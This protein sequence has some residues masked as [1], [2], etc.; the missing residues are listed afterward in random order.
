MKKNKQNK[1][2]KSRKKENTN[3]LGSIHSY[4]QNNKFISFIK[5]KKKKII[6]ISLIFII[7]FLLM[8]YVFSIKIRF[9]LKEQM[10]LE[11]IPLEKSFTIPRDENISINFSIKLNTPR[12]C[13]S[14]CEFKLIDVSDGEI[15]NE[16]SSDDLKEMYFTYNLNLPDKGE[17][18]KI[19]NYKVSCNNVKSTLCSSN[20]KKYFKTALITVNYELTDEEKK[21]KENLFLDLSNYLNEI[22]QI[23]NRLKKLN[24]VKDNLHNYSDEYF[25]YSNF[26][27]NS[28]V[29]LNKSNHFTYI[30]LWKDQN[31]ILLNNIFYKNYSYDLLNHVENNFDDLNNLIIDFNYFVK[32]LNNF[33]SID[34]FNKVFTFYDKLNFSEKFEILTLTNNYNNLVEKIYFNNYKSYNKIIDETNLLNASSNYILLNFE[35]NFNNNFKNFNFIL[36]NILELL[37]GHEINYFNNFNNFNNTTNYLINNTNDSIMNLNEINIFLSE[38]NICINLDLLKNKINIFNE[39]QNLFL[40]N[41]YPFINQNDLFNQSLNDYFLFKIKLL[42]FFNES[43]YVNLPMLYMVNFSYENQTTYNISELDLD[44]IMPINFNVLK[45]YYDAFCSDT[46]KLNYFDND[47]DEINFE[48]N[49]IVFDNILN[50]SI[51]Q[52]NKICCF[53]GG[54]N[55]CCIDDCDDLYPVIFLHGH[56]ISVDNRPEMSH[57]A[58]AKIQDL[59]ENEGYINAGHLG[60]GQVGLIPNGDWGKIKAPFSIRLSY[61]LIKNY[62]I[63]SYSLITQK[64]DNIENYALR[65]NEL[66]KV[67]KQRTGK[68]KVDIVAHSMGGLV[69]REYVY[70]FGSNSVNKMVLV[71]TPNYGIEG[72]VKRLCSLTGASRECNDMNKDSTF[73]RKI[74]RLDYAPDVD[75]YTIRAIGCDMSGDDGDGIVLA[76]NVPLSYATNY[77]IKGECTDF[78]NSDL[79]TRFLDPDIYPQTYELIKK[80]IL[81]N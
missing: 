48:I 53:N 14:Y 27:N 38:K 43:K 8:F 25:Y 44:L 80:I 33:K 9:V 70:L 51:E 60:E 50:L 64:T 45:N 10:S 46:I 18:Q 76:D 39:N 57:E 41:N 31:Y 42:D 1:K 5:R 55:D 4:F 16:T 28:N 3:I 73:M 21:L 58:F 68:D 26:Y 35:K 63:G 61:Y 47:L 81:E 6:I 11:M 36:K 69:A 71:G 56:A 2:D 34:L 59:L 32:Y 65:L 19:F 79:H 24:Y 72:R 22:N 75:M 13:R 17:G 62:D 23:D 15:I 78:L 29:K 20:E 12:L 74:N 54:C 40:N 7:L 30:N 37:P 66:I 77:E 52:N 67:V 49:D